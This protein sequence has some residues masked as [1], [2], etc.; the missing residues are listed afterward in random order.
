M[1]QRI[2]TECD[3]CIAL[4]ESQSGS[5]VGVRALSIEVEVDLCD[6]HVKPLTELLARFVEVGRTP[7]EAGSG[8]R[9]AC[10]RCRKAFATGQA[11]GVHTRRVHGE[12]VVEAREAMG[13]AAASDGHPC[14]ECGKRFASPNGLGPHRAKAHGYRRARSQAVAAPSDE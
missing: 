14:P 2:V 12:T 3:E 5:T 13:Q 8:E 10:P 11:L 9:V 6:V 7:G 1:A 4:G